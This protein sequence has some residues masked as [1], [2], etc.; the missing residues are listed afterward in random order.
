MLEGTMEKVA[1]DD[2]GWTRGSAIGDGAGIT[3]NCNSDW[4]ISSC[5]FLTAN[6]LFKVIRRSFW[7][8]CKM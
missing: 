4:L 3:V 2:I 8:D 5:Y 7:Y 1:V 6:D